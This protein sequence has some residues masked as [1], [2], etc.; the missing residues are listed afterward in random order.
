MR[1]ISTASFARR[2]LWFVPALSAPASPSI[3]ALQHIFNP[4]AWPQ[5]LCNK[6]QES[7]KAGLRNAR[8]RSNVSGKAIMK[9]TL[10][11]WRWRSGGRSAWSFGGSRKI[12]TLRNYQM[13]IGPSAVKHLEWRGASRQE[14]RVQIVFCRVAAQSLSIKRRFILLRRETRLP[15]TPPAIDLQPSAAN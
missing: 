7:N 9:S 10:E 4:A 6:V 2:S 15:A 11:T 13:L 5:T 12:N 3:S 14:N 1:F 8:E